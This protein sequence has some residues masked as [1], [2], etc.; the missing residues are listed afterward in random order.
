MKTCAKCGDDLEE[1]NFYK[2]RSTCIPCFKL[3]VDA[4]RAKY[5]PKAEVEPVPET[6]KT[7]PWRMQVNNELFQYLQRL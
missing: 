3:Q 4:K 7:T 1:D 6:I 2:G 5:V